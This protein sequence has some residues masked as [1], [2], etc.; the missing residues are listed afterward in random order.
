MDPLLPRKPQD[1]DRWSDQAERDPLGDATT[2]PHDRWANE[3]A[4]PDPDYPAPEAGTGA[5][6]TEL[7]S[8]G[9]VGDQPDD[10]AIH[11]QAR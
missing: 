4:R 7:E 9:A 8:D 5:L 1:V 2:G 10:P 11:G 6:N 3:S